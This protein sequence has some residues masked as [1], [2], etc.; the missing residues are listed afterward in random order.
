VTRAERRAKERGKADRAGRCV[1]CITRPTKPG[2]KTC[3]KCQSDARLRSTKRRRKA[4]IGERVSRQ[5]AGAT[6]RFE[7]DCLNSDHESITGMTR[8]AVRSSY[9]AMFR[10]VGRPFVM[11]QRALGYAIDRERGGLRMYKDHGVTYFRGTYQGRPCWYFVWS[12]IEQI[13]TESAP[14]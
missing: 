3:G 10:E 1:T 14:T 7:V 4:G 5:P 2:H 12:H 11:R 9:R 6:W 8:G 13:F